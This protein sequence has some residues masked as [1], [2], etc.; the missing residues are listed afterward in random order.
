M[1]EIIRDGN[2]THAQLQDLA[3]GYSLTLAAM[4]SDAATF[5]RAAGN[6]LQ[7]RI[8]EL[9]RRFVKNQTAPGPL[10]AA[11]RQ[12]LVRHA[13]GPR[14]AAGGV[15]DQLGRAFNES[16]LELGGARSLLPPIRPED[17]IPAAMEAP[18]PPPAP[19][20]F[21]QTCA[22][23]RTDPPKL[24]MLLKISPVRK[25][26]PPEWYLHARAVLNLPEAGE[27]PLLAAYAE[28]ER[29]SPARP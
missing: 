22:R 2:W 1:A 12:F 13:A 9:A 17:L 29:I 25:A 5:Q 6:R 23:L 20:E 16:L 27:D 10:I 28:L 19:G 21:H 3:T 11:W 8:L 15:V 7:Q 4:Q 14:C 26:S 24:I 18:A